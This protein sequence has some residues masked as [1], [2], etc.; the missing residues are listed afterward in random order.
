M[1]VANRTIGQKSCPLL[2]L[3]FNYTRCGKILNTLQ[4]IEYNPSHGNRL[5]K[6]LPCTLI[7][8]NFHFLLRG[9]GQGLQQTLAMEQ[10]RF[11]AIIGF[12]AVGNKVVFDL[13]SSR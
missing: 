1:E 13:Q 8:F 7:R 6:R 10:N 11:R 4:T 2:N 9:G 12:I 3:F 5:N